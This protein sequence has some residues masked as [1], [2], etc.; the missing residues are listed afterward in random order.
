MRLIP[1]YTTAD[2]GVRLFINGQLLINDWTDK[3]N[4]TSKTNSI[5]LAAQQLYNIELDYY[6][7]TNNASVVLAWSSPSTPQ[8]IVPQTQLYP[9][10]NPPPSVV[11]T[12]ADQQ[13]DQLHRRRE[14]DHQRGCRRAYNPI[15]TVNFYANSTLLGSVDQFALHH[16]GDGNWRRAIMR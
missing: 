8:A 15:S 14:R 5:A 4:A 12:R 9:F 1:F 10:T 16:H 11:L 7:K 3:T 2:D 6:Q 13:R